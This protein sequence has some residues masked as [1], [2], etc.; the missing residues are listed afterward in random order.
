MTYEIY[1]KCSSFICW[2]TILLDIS[3]Q[4]FW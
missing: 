2:L 4:S 1:S 3:S